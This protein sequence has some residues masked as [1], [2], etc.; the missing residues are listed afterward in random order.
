MKFKLPVLLCLAAVFAS[1]LHAATLTQSATEDQD[2]NTVIVMGMIHSGHRKHEVYNIERVQDLVRKIKPDY[3]LTEIP[4]DRLAAAEKQFRDT[5]QITEPRVRVFP[6]YT[7]ALFPLTKEMDFKVIPCAA[8]TEEMNNSRRATMKKLKTTHADQ[9]AEMERAQQQA[10][11][12]I[13]ALGDSRDPAVIH[14]P[15]YDAFVKEGM[16]PYDDHFND[17]IGAG[18][19]SNIN[20]AHYALIEQALDEHRGKGKTFL[21][22]FG[23]WHKYYIKEQLTKRKDVNLVSLQR[24][25]SN[26]NPDQLLEAFA[27]QW[28]ESKWVQKFRRKTYMRELGDNGW[29]ARMKLLQ[30][31]VAKGKDS[32][33]ALEKHLNSEHIPTRIVAAQAISYLAR[34]ANV[35][36]LVSHL[37][38]EPD[39][40]VR[41]Y[42]VDAIGM[43][44]KGQDVDWKSIVG[45]ERNRDVRMHIN[46]ATERKDSPVPEDVVNTLA[47]FDV[48]SLPT[49]EKGQPAPDF[50]LKSLDG[51]EFT[52]S[53]FEGVKPVVL[54]FVYGDT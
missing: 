15:Q 9:Y 49:V 14:T 42:L 53:Q 18:G 1:Q 3:V 47:N 12:N 52:L 40:A 28:D 19:W 48:E 31:L 13:A 30:Q 33:P 25:L 2:K 51:P 41:L 44:G 54:V 4:P 35:K 11:T 36:N 26:G 17:L 22:T 37:K 50:T 6:E 10:S 39:A 21:I 32:I 38:D 27:N 8:W 5:G 43:S 16:K 24:Y 7:D 46:Y 20:A 34:H 29:R 45:G 23:S